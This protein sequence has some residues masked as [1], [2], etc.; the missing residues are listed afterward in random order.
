MWKTK[1]DSSLNQ[2]YYENTLDGSVTFD[3]PCEVHNAKASKPKGCDLVRPNLLSR[4]TSRL[5]FCRSSS[6]ENC[7]F[8]AAGTAKVVEKTSEVPDSQITSLYL[9][10][11]AHIPLSLE[12]SYMLEEP[13][14]LYNSD[15][16]SISSDESVQSFYLELLPNDI[17][18]DHEHSIYY[19]DKSIQHIEEDY[20][21]EQERLE[22]RLQIL[23]ELY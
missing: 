13:F 20:D 12:D 4:L 6:L 22:L 8:R 18:Y 16:S 5:P 7:R 21:K 3:L 15:A 2:I 19:D 23:R 11:M 9:S 10:G 17:Y 1:F 14:N